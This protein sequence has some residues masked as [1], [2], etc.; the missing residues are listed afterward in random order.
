ML[1]AVP[2]AASSKDDPAISTWP[3]L[4]SL[5]TF[6]PLHHDPNHQ[7]LRAHRHPLEQRLS[8]K[9]RSFLPSCLSSFFACFL[10]PSR[11][12]PAHPVHTVALNR[13]ATHPASFFYFLWFWFGFI[14]FPFV[15]SSHSYCIVHPPNEPGPASIQKLPCRNYILVPGPPRQDLCPPSRSHYYR[16]S[17]HNV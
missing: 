12:M 3:T 11:R 13:S 14:Y 10:S 8:R 6:L 16:K 7:H 2:G 1:S 17:L 9:I 5:M 15:L 4:G